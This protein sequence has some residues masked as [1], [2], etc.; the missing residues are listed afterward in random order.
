MVVVGKV[1]KEEITSKIKQ[2]FSSIPSKDYSLAPL[3]APV[4]TTNSLVSEQRTLATNYLTGAVAAPKMTSPD[5]VPYKL[6]ITVLGDRL[7]K[8]IR[9]KR[10]LS[11]D[12]DAYS[13]TRQLPFGV[14]EASTTD[15]K[16]A[17]QVMV[18]EVKKLTTYGFYE[19]ELRSAK[20]GFITT[21]Y[22]REQSTGAIA[23][24]LGIAEIMGDWKLA[25][26]MPYRVTKVTLNELNNSMKYF[27]YI[28]WTYLGD[29]KLIKDGAGVFRTSE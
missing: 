6:A 12:P 17:A 10:N 13:T 27:A 1:T 28:K 9:I 8:E 24:S 7:F 18:D 3:K 16:A 25:D 20:N 19:G 26:E 2:A 23:A 4:Y 15:P 14:M 11:Y 5:Y 29:E 21:N 22:M